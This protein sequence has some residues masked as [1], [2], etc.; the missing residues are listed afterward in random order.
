MKRRAL[1]E[2]SS[3][4]LLTPTLIPLNTLL[5]IHLFAEIKEVGESKKIHTFG[6]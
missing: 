5:V 1:Y 4:T 2:K 6:R 3:G